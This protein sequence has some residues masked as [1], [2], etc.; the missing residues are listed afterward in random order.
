MY[1]YKVSHCLVFSLSLIFTLA[2]ET[3]AGLLLQTSEIMRIILDTELVGEQGPMGGG[4]NGMGGEEDLATNN[5]NGADPNGKGG[6]PNSTGGEQNSFL[7]MF[8]EHYVQWLVAPLKY[9]I[10][11]PRAAFPL[12]I[13]LS[14]SL[15]KQSIE[16]EFKS[17]LGVMNTSRLMGLVP[18]CAIRTSFAIELLSFCVRAHCLR[19][20][21]FVLRSRCLGI[22]LKLLSPKASASVTSGDRCL[23]LASL[24]SVFFS[25]NIYLGAFPTIFLR[26]I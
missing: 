11:Q 12:N 8:Y 7:A 2:V 15:L 4:G 9:A 18:A 20:K 21:F 26:V 10:L 22:V 6:S 19:M 5:G 3:D 23:K 13:T 16:Q 1:T 25:Q 17:V 14:Q 24:R